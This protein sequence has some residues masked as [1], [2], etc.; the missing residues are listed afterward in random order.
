[1]SAEGS[2][3]PNDTT[4]S[5]MRTYQAGVMSPGANPL[6]ATGLMGLMTRNSSRYDV[7]GEGVV[8]RKFSLSVSVE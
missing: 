1:M 3:I 6:P 7:P 5:A 4:A 8:H 2:G